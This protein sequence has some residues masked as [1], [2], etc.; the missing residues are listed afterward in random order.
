VNEN[1]IRIGAIADAN[2]LISHLTRLL[3][4]K[5]AR[6]SIG[7]PSLGRTV[8]GEFKVI[9]RLG[10]ALTEMASAAENAAI[11]VAAQTPMESVFASRVPEELETAVGVFEDFQIG[12]S[13]LR[14]FYEESFRF[15]TGRPVRYGEGLEEEDPGAMIEA[16]MERDAERDYERRRE[17][18]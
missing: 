13:A 4:Q 18:L 12:P 8:A 11:H 16:Q 1:D 9:R 10:E 14:P 6:E 2:R 3:A 7:L 15:R 17:V 5:P